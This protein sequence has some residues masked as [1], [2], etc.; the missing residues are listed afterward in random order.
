VSTEQIAIV[1]GAVVGVA[2]VLAPSLTARLDRNHQRKLA[3][4]QRRHGFRADVYRSAG[5]F[6]ERQRLLRL[7]IEP[8]WGP[9]SPPPDP[10]ADED[11]TRLEGSIAVASS[12][13]VR[14][15]IGEAHR[16]ANQFV[17][18]AI[19]YRRQEPDAGVKMIESRQ[20]ALDA[21]DEAERLMNT[22]LVAL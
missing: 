18:D 4:A 15:A 20:R 9:T 12:P 16:R 17:V 19:A 6:L 13:E 3:Q 1:A 2:G 8:I 14:A 7:R 21:L 11:W 5:A 22:E 10:L